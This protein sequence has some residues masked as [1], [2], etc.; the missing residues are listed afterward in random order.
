MIE[1][2]SE[3]GVSIS[4]K[5]SSQ[6][7]R[8]GKGRSMII[9]PTDYV[10]VDLETTGLS[11]QFDEII[12]ISCLRIRD[13]IVTDD[14]STLVK[15]KCKIDDYTSELTG[16]T[17]EMVANAPPLENILHN[18]ID[19]IGEDL[20]V[21]HNV[22]FDV[23]FLYDT[24][25][26]EFDTVISNDYVDTLRISRKLYPELKHHRLKDI[27]ERA[28]ISP[29]GFHRALNDC[30]MTYNCFE[31]MR[32]EICLTYQNT[33][34]F[35]SLFSNKTYTKIDARKLTAKTTEFDT[36]HP[37]YG[38]VCV[39]TGVLEKMDRKTAMQTVLDI[40]GLC[41]NSVTKK[42]NYL[43]LGNYD[44]CS[45]VKNGKSTKQMKAEQYKLNGYD[46]EIIP[47]NVFYDMIEQ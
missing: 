2:N 32:K 38:K 23:N 34:I 8:E 4:N 12:E 3:K 9:F 29:E 17:N 40:G 10:V 7:H 36:S 13:R 15:P 47:E 46:I 16:I 28:G 31:S 21:G 11:S 39:F 45:T 41:A 37:L 44:Y 35:A 5:S 26:S 14:F 30:Y 6:K 18:V 20:I 42:T 33:E 27:V 43:I 22:S 25:F 24:S 1:I 19:F